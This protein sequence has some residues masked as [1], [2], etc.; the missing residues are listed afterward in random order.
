MMRQGTPGG[1]LSGPARGSGTVAAV[2]GLA[3]AWADPG[4]FV[5]EGGSDE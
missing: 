5:T 2:E 3:A 4:R 1:N